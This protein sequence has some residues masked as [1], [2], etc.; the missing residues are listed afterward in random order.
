MKDLPA[1]YNFK[2]LFGSAP[3]A[4]TKKGSEDGTTSIDQVQD[5]ADANDTKS[6]KKKKHWREYLLARSTKVEWCSEFWWLE[7]VPD[8]DVKL[9]CKVALLWK[10]ACT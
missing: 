6:K 7:K 1:D 10:K 9:N 5:H 2:P 3:K 8:N 4:C